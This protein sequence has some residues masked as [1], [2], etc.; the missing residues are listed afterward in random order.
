[1]ENDSKSLPMIDVIVVV[2][3]LAIIGVFIWPL[4]MPT[5]KVSR[6]NSC[7]NNLKIIGICLITYNQGPGQDC[8][9]P[10][11]SAEKEAKHD[12]CG[13]Q[14]VIG[15]YDPTDP[16]LC[17][18]YHYICPESPKNAVAVPSLWDFGCVN[19]YNPGTV[20]DG[21]DM[22]E[23]NYYGWDEAAASQ[24]PAPQRSAGS[25]QGISVT[26]GAAGNMSILK[27][28]S[29]NVIVMDQ[30]DSDGPGNSNH[31][32]G[33]NCLFGD[34]HVEFMLYENGFMDAATS[35]GGTFNPASALNAGATKEVIPAVTGDWSLG[36][37]CNFISTSDT[38]E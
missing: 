20:P 17:D 21:Q 35:K 28:G 25:G 10:T 22:V 16:D 34:G 2:V 6:R 9:Y 15:L 30:D 12:I 38:K 14:F 4:L 1:M 27:A 11:G 32:D 23:T 7:V 26:V 5:S 31:P 18:K 33:V 3:I 37:E 19:I 13:R 36:Y 24:I 8:W 29:R